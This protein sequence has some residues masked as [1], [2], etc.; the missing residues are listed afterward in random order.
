MG[1]KGIYWNPQK[2][3]YDLILGLFSI[4]FLLVFIITTII[5][6]PNIS[7]ET[8]IIRAM[9]SLAIVLLHI[10]LAI[11]PLARID[12]RFIPLLY[13]RRHAGVLM[14]C[15]AATHGL[16]SLIQF[17]SRAQISLLESLFTTNTEWNSFVDFPFQVLGFGALILLAFMALTS[18]DF[19]LKLLSPVFWKRIHMGVY[20]AYLLLLGHILTGPALESHPIYAVL[21]FGGF[22]VLSFLHI[23]SGSFY[24]KDKIEA[25]ENF[26]KACSIQDIKDNCAKIIR[27]E[28][29]EIAIFK[30]ENKLSAVHNLCKHQ[31]G[32]LGEGRIIDG[33]I[34]CPWHGYQ[35]LPE[36]GTSPPP[37]DEKVKT[38]QLRLIGDDVYVN[39]KSPGE[40]APVES[41]HIKVESDE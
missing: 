30:Y 19:W 6:K 9:G 25:D 14:F 22:V 29:E 17:H 40:G 12:S 11:G 20:V 37:F 1:Y 35:Y 15:I 3:K 26:V 32:P 34:T 38:F 23:K 31:N 13:N 24:K 2:K 39:P 10:I 16:F 33:C 21:L 36:N 4:L 7:V 8:I 41:I 27:V 18:H 28:N 5:V